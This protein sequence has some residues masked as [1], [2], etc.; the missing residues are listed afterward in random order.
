MTASGPKQKYVTNRKTDAFDP[1]ADIAAGKVVGLKPRIRR[2][3]NGGYMQRRKF[4]TL[5][6]AGVKPSLGRS[7][8][9]RSKRR[10]FRP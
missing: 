5:L 6:S 7:R 8:R 4:I 10:S 9:V 3:P 2:D 1:T